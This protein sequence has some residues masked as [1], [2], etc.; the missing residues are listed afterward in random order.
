MSPEDAKKLK[1]R[2]RSYASQEAASEAA[3]QADHD[4]QAQ[5]YGVKA[6]A[7]W[8]EIVELIDGLV[9]VPNR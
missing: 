9:I 8:K 6:E 3:Y 2:I 1:M 5:R 4:N 7:L